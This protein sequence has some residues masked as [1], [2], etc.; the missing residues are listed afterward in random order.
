MY[1]PVHTHDVCVAVFSRDVVLTHC[2]TLQHTATHCNT[3]QHAVTHCNTLQH[4]ATH[5]NTLQ[6]TVPHSTTLQHTATHS[7][8]LQHTATHCNTLQH[9]ATH[10]YALQHKGCCTCKPCPGY[11]WLH[12]VCSIHGRVFSEENSYFHRA[13]LQKRPTNVSS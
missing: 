10:C 12:S 3:L 9:P 2:N 1:T 11:W 5:C 4:T 6:H 13:L 8:T 7:N